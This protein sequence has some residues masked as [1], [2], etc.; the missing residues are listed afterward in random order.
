MTITTKYNVGDEAYLMRNNKVV[1]IKITA[2]YTR[3]TVVNNVPELFITYMTDNNNNKT[4]LE[5]KL[6]KTKE[7]LLKTL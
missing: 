7:E 5:S 3:T 2:V 4:Y 6:H 1:K